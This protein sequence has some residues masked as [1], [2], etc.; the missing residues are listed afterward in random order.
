RGAYDARTKAV[1][2]Q[3][4]PFK[5]WTFG[6]DLYIYGLPAVPSGR[7]AHV[8]VARLKA[9]SAFAQAADPLGGLRLLAA[10]S[11]VAQP[12]PG[13][14]TGTFDLAL[15]ARNA[16]PATALFVAALRA[17]V[18]GPTNAIPFTAATAEGHLAEVT[19][20]F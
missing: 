18:K 11:S 14:F 17:N 6:P 2:I 7:I 9:D 1:V 3:E 5:V 19:T 8:D 4:G 15:V 12:E 13:R 10:A 16:P 20:T